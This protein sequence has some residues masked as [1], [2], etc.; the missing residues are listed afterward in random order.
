[1]MR[2]SPPWR[3][4]YRRSERHLAL[5]DQLER[6]D[7]RVILFFCPR[8]MPA[9]A[10]VKGSIKMKSVLATVGLSFVAIF[11]SAGSAWAAGE[12]ATVSTS[13]SATSGTFYPSV[14][15]PTTL[16]VEFTVSPGSGQTEILP[17]KEA[18]FNL[19]SDVS[20]VPHPGTTPIC[21]DSELSEN[22]NLAL[23]IDS[24]IAKCPTSV[25]GNGTARFY[26]A[27]QVTAPLTDV[28]LVVFYGGLD[29]EN[30]V[31][32]KIYAFSQSTN[33]GVLVPGTATTGQIH[34][35]LPVISSDS[36]ISN[37]KLNLPGTDHASSNRRG[38]DLDL[39]QGRCSSG[40]H[41][42]SVDLVLGTRS[43]PTG[44]DTGPESTISSPTQTTPC[45][46]GTD[47]D[48]TITVAP[49]A[50]SFPNR[51]VGDD[52]SA[53]ADLVV[54]G[55]GTEATTIGASTVLGGGASSYLID[56]SACE[57]EALTTNETCT[58][59]VRFSPV[60]TGSKPATL[61]ITSNAVAGPLSVPLSG[62]G[63]TPVPDAAATPS[64]I[65]FGSQSVGARSQTKVIRIANTGVQALRA[66]GV[67]LSGDSSQFEVDATDC[68]D[69][70]L[71]R[72][73]RCV[74]LVDFFPSST[75]AK[76]ATL[77]V[78]SNAASGS[79]TVALSGTGTP[80]VVGPTGPTGST[81]STGSTGPAG[82]PGSTGHTGPVGPTGPT[83]P[84]GPEGPSATG[85]GLDFASPAL[86]RGKSGL[87]SVIVANTG[88]TVLGPVRVSLTS[89]NGKVTVPR[90]AV[91]SSV[92][93][94]SV[95]VTKVK[96]SVKKTARRGI[97]KV[98]A[99]SGALTSSTSVKVR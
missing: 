10:G 66:S 64:S 6:T 48:R 13:Y 30:R 8:K 85:L 62:T 45:S 19:P 96:V 32:L 76:S 70:D 51:Q 21:T 39:V 63:I 53:A 40:Q 7:P 34:L 61:S 47:P 86:K 41:H 94:G 1:M 84:V 4:L 59:K 28:Q 97:V 25:L 92:K 44:Q 72:N 73:G 2:Q 83:G 35:D 91:V 71:P 69:F 81:G 56:D 74:I 22:S 80:T 24:T 49:G 77:T 78:A 27:R 65:A 17:A 43:F 12:T 89:S 9:S 79:K 14:G 75:G 95:K 68:L 29:A 90:K 58:I 37:I 54:T 18:T 16:S 11:V 15:V 60:S 50:L 42:S 55:A 67:S 98:T 23:G 87:L 26:L 93:A 33:V 5:P 52:P 46:S 57:G 36:S 82:N 31:K 3:T 38:R 88:E 20:F 99:R